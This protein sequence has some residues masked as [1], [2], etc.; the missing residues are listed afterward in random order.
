MV[1]SGTLFCWKPYEN[2]VK[3]ILNVH[4]VKYE[5]FN[6]LNNKETGFHIEDHRGY[7]RDYSFLFKH[8]ELFIN[9]GEVDLENEDHY[10]I[11]PEWKYT[12]EKQYY[13]SWIK[14]PLNGELN[15]F[16]LLEE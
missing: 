15:P 1:L 16:D 5:L 2:I 13:T 7:I 11:N 6:S 12:L 14:L 4:D 10:G 3:G 9:F 8:L